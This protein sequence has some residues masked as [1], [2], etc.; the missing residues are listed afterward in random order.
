MTRPKGLPEA[1]SNL[2][3][4]ASN[5]PSTIP[6]AAIPQPPPMMLPI[7]S[8]TPYDIRLQQWVDSVAGTSYN[9]F[10][11]PPFQYYMLIHASN[12]IRLRRQK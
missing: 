8:S 6:G 1:V 2:F 4:R 10:Y 11:R 9:P 3:K 12:D 5:S 7:S